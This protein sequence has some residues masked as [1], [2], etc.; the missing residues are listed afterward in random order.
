MDIKSVIQQHG[1]QIQQVAQQMG[2]KQ[3]SLSAIISGNPTAKTL[4]SIAKT[5]GCPVIEF[6]LDE[7]PDDYDLQSIIPRKEPEML[8]M[9]DTEE[10]QTIAPGVFV[11][12][13][14]GAGV[15]FN[16]FVVKEPS[17]V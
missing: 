5:I 13:H 15:S 17:E 10:S 2:M 7:V 9:S 12:P 14:C 4:Q 6:F 1:M 8:P 16:S 11:C 3:S